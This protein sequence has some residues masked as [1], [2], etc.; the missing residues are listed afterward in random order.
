MSRSSRET[1]GDAASTVEV[2]L[3]RDLPSLCRR[4]LALLLD[5]RD[6]DVTRAWNAARSHKGYRAFRIEADR[7]R[8]VHVPSEPLA[9]LQRRALERVLYN[10]PISPAAFAGVPGRSLL[11]AASCH[12]ADA[13][14][15]V[16]LDIADAFA[17]TGYRHVLGAFR[18]RLRRDLWVLGLDRREGL[19]VVR[20]LTLLLTVSR[21]RGSARRLA[22][23]APSSVALFNLVC[24]PIDRDVWALLDAAGARSSVVYTRYVDDLVVSSSTSLPHDLTARITEII[25]RAGF[26]VN[27]AKLSRER[28]FGAT[29][30]G[31]RRTFR[32]VEPTEA[33]L[34]RYGNFVRLHQDRLERAA[35]SGAGEAAA[36]QSA[37][38]LRG[39]DG[40]LRQ[41]YEKRGAVRPEELR[42]EPPPAP[43]RPAL[44]SIEELW[45]RG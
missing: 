24:L 33:A 32:G 43:P 22:L 6:D 5:L 17:S 14:D 31:F 10:G 12:L 19:Q 23:G 25:Q 16:K 13:R 20:A 8:V 44:E 40:F 27:R 28:G 2:S 34:V 9:E 18:E 1:N 21:G 35:S 7:P 15:I 36:R 26:A 11:D 41:V 42:F 38:A 3:A 30:L 37:F 45:R 39:M 29:V 4:S